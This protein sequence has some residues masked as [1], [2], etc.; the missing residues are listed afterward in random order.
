MSVLKR[1]YG[2][3]VV[4]IV[5]L[6]V[7]SGCSANLDGKA[8][9]LPALLGSSRAAAAPQAVAQQVE[10]TLGEVS[11]TAQPGDAVKVMQG[12]TLIGQTVAGKDGAWSL[13]IPTTAS[14]TEPFHVQIVPYDGR[15]AMPE[16][17]VTIVV[18]VVVGTNRVEV[19][20]QVTSPNGQVDIVVQTPISPCEPQGGDE[21]NAQPQ[22]AQ[23]LDTQ[24]QDAQ[25]QDGQAQQVQGAQPV[26]APTAVPAYHQVVAGETVATIASHYGVTAQAIMQA[27]KL[28]NANLIYVGQRLVI[29]GQKG[30]PK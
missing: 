19:R 8:R 26:A 13:A 21:Q 17:P 10:G 27:N 30:L 15:G 1:A 6:L 23:T 18:V 16:N 22:D 4:M 2:G 9:P 24:T 20:V 28:R 3:I 7:V 29:P 11:G 12:E 5:L 14:K 25:A